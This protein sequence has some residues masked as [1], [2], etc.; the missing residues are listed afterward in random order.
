MSYIVNKPKTR[1]DKTMANKKKNSLARDLYLSMKNAVEMYKW[2]KCESS[3]FTI[4]RI[5]NLYNQLM[6]Q[7]LTVS[8]KR[9]V[10]KLYN[11][12]VEYR[13]ERRFYEL[14]SWEVIQDNFEHFDNDADGDEY[15]ATL[16]L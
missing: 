7:N 3:H 2:F 6:E 15:W 10:K 12:A 9:K 14:E 8:Q 4:Q 5:T 1:K 11:D 16:Y 13:P